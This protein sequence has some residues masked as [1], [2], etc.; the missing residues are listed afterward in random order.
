M[1]KGV[2]GAMCTFCFEDLS[3]AEIN[4][5]EVTVLSEEQIFGLEVTIDHL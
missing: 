2:R 5:F 3:I 1:C 4:Q